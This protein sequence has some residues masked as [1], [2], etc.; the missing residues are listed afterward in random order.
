MSDRSGQNDTDNSLAG[1]SFEGVNAVPPQSGENGDT[2]NLADVAD[3]SEQDDVSNAATET[4]PPLNFASDQTQP[5]QSFPTAGAA[6]TTPAGT[7]PNGAVPTGAIPT[8]DMPSSA[9]APA[10]PVL[11][12]PVEGEA[13]VAKKRKL[14]LIITG[15][16]LAVLVV[17][18]IA[19]FFTAR[20]YFQDKAAPGVTFGG[21]SVA[22]QT[23]DQLK[24]TVTAAVKNTTMNIK[25][26]NGNSASGS[27]S[28]LGVSYNV[29]KT[30]TELL[31]AKHQ[32]NGALE[33]INEVNPFVE[34]NVPLNAKS[35]KL[36]LRTFVTDK[37]VQDTDRA[38]PSTASYDVNAHAFVAV[39]G[40]GGRSP[41]VDNVIDT[42]AKA[43]ANPGHSSSVTITYETID[44]PVALPEAQNVADQANARLNAPIVL[45][46]G[47]GKTFQIP[48]EVVASWLKTDADLEHGTLSLSYDDNAITNYVQQ[49]V[50]AQLNQDAV[51]QE[52]AVDNSGKVLATI[53]KGVNGV[54]VKNMEAL[55]PKI[56]E[57]L[58]NGQG[59]T[60]PVDG[61]VQN[62]KTVQKKS[63]YRI[64]VD[65]TAQT[66]TV[67]HNDEA[68]KTFPVCT[69]TTGKH[70]TDLGTFY[71]YLKY[72][73][74]DMT[75]LND[76]GS[77]Y[78]SKG[79]KWVSYF[80]GGEGFH[81][82]SWNNYGIAHGDPARYGS[83]GCVNMYEA[84][85][86][87]IYD[88]CPE[89]TI[90]QVVGAMPS[91]PVR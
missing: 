87:W 58:K 11:T 7:V 1:I 41:K 15:I 46:N 84:D 49:Q 52:D 55:A 63:E 81:T 13:V 91:G 32:T 10:I 44:V 8:G 68:V 48:A 77:R 50:P 28:D 60:I 33:Y 19:G 70:E 69:G 21:T 14:P 2:I 27:L 4:M 66:A 85:S 29:D 76:D 79:V 40:R 53:V 24:N 80:Y 45:D 35:N 38:V 57:A 82:A 56:G 47:Q 30:V 23:A 34:K 22:G 67:Y 18:A 25:D 83:H 54:K 42:V 5:F 86:K 36:A 20:W 51:D 75:G 71:I 74:Q 3:V 39:E 37:F 16:V 78:L 12:M 65:R 9:P 31:A 64:V 26:G 72:Q 88:N 6:E 89:G 73:I 90:V 62:F 61:D 17:A 43:I 59:A